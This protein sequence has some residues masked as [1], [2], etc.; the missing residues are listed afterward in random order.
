MQ[1]LHK[2]IKDPN[3]WRSRSMEMRSTA[4]KTADRKAKASMMGAADAYNKLAKETKGAI[5]TATSKAF[6]KGLLVPAIRISGHWLPSRAEGRLIGFLAKVA[7][8][9]TQS[10]CERRLRDRWTSG[11]L[12]TM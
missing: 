2:V 4:E 11:P 7:T 12:A 9:C 1:R 8:V 10:T 3:H 5:F 6:P